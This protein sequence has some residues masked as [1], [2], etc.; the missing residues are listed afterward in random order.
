MRLGLE[1]TF[2]PDRRGTKEFPTYKQADRAAAKLGKKL[3]FPFTTNQADN[4]LDPVHQFTAKAERFR[5]SERD[6]NKWVGF[7]VEVNL[8]PFDHTLLADQVFIEMLQSVFDEAAKMGLLP[9][10]RRRSIHHPTG[11]SHLLLGLTDLFKDDQHFLPSLVAFERSLLVDS[12][13]RPYIRWLFAE[14]FDNRMNHEVVIPSTDLS[15][16]TWSTQY[17]YSYALYR[18][19]IRRRFSDDSKT[20]YSAYE[21]RMFDATTCAADVKRDVDFL[22]AWVTHIKDLVLAEKP[23][24][25]NLTIKRYKTWSKPR[26]AWEEVSFFLRLLKLDPNNYREPFNDNY[27]NRIRHGEMN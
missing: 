2:V 18:G 10:I 24:E 27:L 4:R 25:F 8:T 21:F 19:F 14:W 9:R 12:A 11:G 1:L 13:N 6:V 15:V 20:P 23:V 16:H 7:I 22:V 5:R 26:A 17:V 3:P